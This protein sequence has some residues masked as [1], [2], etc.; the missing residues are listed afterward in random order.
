MLTLET[1][2]VP[3]DEGV[4]NV[5]GVGDGDGE[6]GGV[7]LFNVSH[8]VG[9]IEVDA[10]HH[11]HQGQRDEV[12]L[13]GRILVRLSCDTNLCEF[14]PVGLVNRWCL[15]AHVE[16]NVL[17]A[18]QEDWGVREDARVVGGKV[19]VCRP[20][21]WHTGDVEAVGVG[22]EILRTGRGVVHRH[23]V[24]GLLAGFNHVIERLAFIKLNVDLT[25]QHV[26]IT[27]GEPVVVTFVAARVGV[28]PRDVRTAS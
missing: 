12:V 27:D 14:I 11:V 23:V 2:R 13:N 17:A 9:G 20:V 10:V 26:G 7:A 24:D 6:D 28:G 22:H 1:V 3:E 18:F 4:V 25:G 8:A 16:A 19:E 15:D 5:A 21:H